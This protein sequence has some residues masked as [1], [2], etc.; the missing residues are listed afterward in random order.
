MMLVA[1]LRPQLAYIAKTTLRSMMAAGAN[2]DSRIASRAG[3][4]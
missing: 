1:K 2:C 4:E 3:F